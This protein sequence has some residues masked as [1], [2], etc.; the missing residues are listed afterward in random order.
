MIVLVKNM[1][2]YLCLAANPSEWLPEHDICTFY[3]LCVGGTAVEQS[4]ENVQIALHNATL[5]QNILHIVN[6]STL[7][8]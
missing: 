2:S 4:N 5:V 6:L 3:F 8:I 7:F 1:L